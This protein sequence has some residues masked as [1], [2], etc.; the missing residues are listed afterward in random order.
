MESDGRIRNTYTSVTKDAF[1]NNVVSGL[2]FPTPV[3]SPW[4]NY[5]K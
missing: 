3:E 5:L 1:K 2:K 4:Y